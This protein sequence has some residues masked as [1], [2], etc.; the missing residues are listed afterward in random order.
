MPAADDAFD[1]AAL[2]ERLASAGV[3]FVVIGAVAGGAHGSAYGT[4]NIDLAFTDRPENV[5][6]LS[7]ALT[8]IGADGPFEPPA[9]SCQTSLGYVKCFA[10]PIG[11]RSYDA[12]RA[13]AWPIDV[14]GATVWIAALD[15]LIGM[16][17]GQGRT[18]DK[19][20]AMEYRTISD[21][22]RAPPES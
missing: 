17:E 18:R 8:E 19:L 12:L 21:E 4:F 13:E 7:A 11:V 3:D 22:L 1:P 2:F 9:F 14:R 5:D 16:K 15:Q 20:L 6:R 10:A